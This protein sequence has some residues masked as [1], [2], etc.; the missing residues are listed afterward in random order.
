M[1]IASVSV[2]SFIFLP[3]VHKGYGHLGRIKGH[4]NR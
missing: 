3:R 1:K 4:P 2:I